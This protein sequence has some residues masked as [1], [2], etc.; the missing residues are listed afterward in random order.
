MGNDDL[1]LTHILLVKHQDKFWTAQLLGYAIVQFSDFHTNQPY[2]F[3]PLLHFA[4][5]L[6]FVAKVR[7]IL[8]IMSIKV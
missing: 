5:N 3:L 8:E 2:T 6:G 1:L 7:R 4:S